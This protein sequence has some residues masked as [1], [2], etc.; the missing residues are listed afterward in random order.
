MAEYNEEEK[1][2][3]PDQRGSLA[4][5]AD[6]ATAVAVKQVSAGLKARKGRFDDIQKNEDQYSGLKTKAL[7]GRNNVPFD[8]VVA[9]GF[10]DTL[11]SKI[12]EGLEMSYER[13]AGRQQDKKPALKLTAAV[14]HLRGADQGQWDLKD[15]GGKKL[16]I[17]SGRAIFKKYSA[18]EKDG[19][20][21]DYFENVDH[22]DFVTE[23]MGGGFLDKHLYKGQ[24]NIF[25]TLEDLNDAAEDGTYNK[26]QVAK[27]IKGQDEGEDKQNRQDM[28]DQQKRAAAVGVDTS[29]SQYVGGRV[30]R[31][32]EWVMYFQ[33]EW[34]YVVFNREHGI[35]L[36]FEKLEDVFSVAKHY[37]G[38]GPWISWATHF[39]PFV[40]WSLGPMD[41]IRPI[42][43]AIKKVMNLSLD[44]LEKRNWGQRA[45][46]PNV[47]NPRDLL[48]KHDGLVKANVRMGE[49]VAGK[50]YTFETPDTTN[51][52]INLVDWMNNFLGEQTGITAAA[53][54]AGADGGKVGIYMGNIQQVADRLGLTNKM[55]QQ[56]HVD[57]GV[58]AQWGLFDHMPEE[59]AVKIIGN[60]GIEWNETLKRED[61]EHRFSIRVV[62]SNAEEKLNVVLAQRKQNALMMIQRD[63][64]ARQNVNPKWYIREILA[65]G[66]YDA[67]VV[68]MAIDTTSDADDD[69]LSDAAQAIEDIIEGREPRMYRNATTAFIK[70][71]MDYAYDT[72][73]DMKL[74]NKL[75]EYAKKHIPLAQKNME[76]Q[77][78]KVQTAAAMMGAT[79][80]GVP[81][82]GG[83]RPSGPIDTATP[84]A[85]ALSPAGGPGMAAGALQ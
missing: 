13:A 79:G 78:T 45:Y 54:G 81:A 2:N 83:G 3:L 84:G 21:C 16:A 44:N 61:V 36:R 77:V 67:E 5:L 8:A 34:Y 4:A 31:L 62:G 33:G 46:D 72:D 75:I 25:R 32:V 68:R 82:P 40:F 74:F 70:K 20:F 38:R 41:S 7:R 22:W 50:V 19:E 26:R 47:F 12:D 52:T 73:I 11:M 64:V 43:A 29:T 6:K 69:I 53:K 48:W 18:R 80:G 49:P 9:R 30:F 17:F 57:I 65:L 76:R 24:I 56:C 23:A 37:P 15:L 10:V 35:W 42:A 14:D 1:N 59:Y 71:I 55:Y 28:E 58:N 63:P 85:P 66:G 60:A 51:I 27:L 39:D